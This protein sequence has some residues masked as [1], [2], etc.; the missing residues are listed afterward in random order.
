[1]TKKVE[2]NW[3]YQGFICL[4]ILGIY[5]YGVSHIWGMCIYPDE[6]GYWSTAARMAG[7]DWSQITSLGSYY[8]FGYSILLYPI[9]MLTSDSVAAYRLAVMLNAVLMCVASFLLQKMGEEL[10][11]NRS[12]MYRILLSGISVLYP[13]WIF[14]MQTTMTEAILAFMVILVGYLFLKLL[15]KPGVINAIL[16]SLAVGYTYTL[17]MRAVGLVIACILTVLIWGILEKKSRKS[18]LVV[19]LCIILVFFCAYSIKEVVQENI[20]SGSGL[21]EVNDYGGQ[22]G[23][24]KSLFS[25]QGIKS[26]LLLVAGKTLYLNLASGGL[27]LWGIWRNIKNSFQLLQE[28]RKRKPITSQYLFSLYLVLLFLGELGINCIY[29]IKSVTLDNLLYGRYIEFI[30]PIYVFWGGICIGEEFLKK[31]HLSKILLPYMISFLALVLGVWNT[32]E[33]Y[34]RGVH[35]AILNIFIQRDKLNP[36]FFVVT[37][38][39]LGLL[40]LFV[41]SFLLRFVVAKKGRELVLMFFIIL[42]L[43]LGISNSSCIIYTGNDNIRMDLT[44]LNLME[45]RIAS[46]DEVMFLVE[47]EN[48]WIA[49]LQMQLR[50]EK[51]QAL[52]PEE[53]KNLVAEDTILFT[54]W[55]SKYL[56]ELD[57]IYEQKVMG[58]LYYLYYN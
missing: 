50:D 33:G 10:F 18:T 43:L 36:L 41:T 7:W 26:I 12:E 22:V 19:I 2:K 53:L 17:H 51:I 57:K 35:S 34:I 25:S 23:K 52:K 20:Y 28:I 48:Q 46:E 6:F 37:I 9:L 45:D 24:I 13:S 11:P 32:L 58:D 5:G 49:F 39:S 8:S 40:Y 44:L 42:N 16:L 4:L 56:E 55:D 29:T 1:M 14:Y 27:V 30:A 47:G 21:L 15:E 31:R 54:Y 38:G 3:I